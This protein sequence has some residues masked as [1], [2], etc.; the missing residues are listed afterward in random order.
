MSLK[1]IVETAEAELAFQLALGFECWVAGDV[2]G[3]RL[4]WHRASRCELVA[5]FARGLMG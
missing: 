2:L 3:L 1:R 4:A 5:R